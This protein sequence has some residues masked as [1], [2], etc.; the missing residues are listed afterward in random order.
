VPSNNPL[1]CLQPNDLIQESMFKHIWKRLSEAGYINYE[2]SNFAKPGKESFHNMLYWQDQPYWGVGLSA[3]SYLKTGLWGERFW[4]PKNLNEY[5]QWVDSQSELPPSNREILN[6][7]QSLSDFCHTS[8][9][10]KSGLSL[11]QV[12]GKYGPEKLIEVGTILEQ[13][14]DDGFIQTADR[15]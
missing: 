1:Y 10:T 6:G 8:L 5:C 4:N 13:L 7:A 14:H 9:R 15:Q 12:Q 3:H 2:I 11:A